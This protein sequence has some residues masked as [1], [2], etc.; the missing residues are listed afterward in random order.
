MPRANPGNYG[1]TASEFLRAIRGGRSQRALARRLDYRANPITDWE[2]GRRFPTAEEAL[3]DA[4]PGRQ[5][6]VTAEVIHVDPRPWGIYAK[7]AGS[8]AG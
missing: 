3:T 5:T 6:F 8:A 4:S 1:R 2:H 7:S